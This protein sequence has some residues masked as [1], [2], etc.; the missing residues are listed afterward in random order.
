MFG[1]L[2]SEKYIPTPSTIPRIP[3]PNGERAYR[4][5]TSFGVTRSDAERRGQK[6]NYFQHR[7]ASR[8]KQALLGLRSPQY[9]FRCGFLLRR[10]TQFFFLLE[11]MD[12]TKLNHSKLGTKEYWDNFYKLEKENF[13][14]NPEDTGECWFA[15][16]GAEER[17]VDFVFS[18]LDPNVSICDLGTGNGHLL[19]EILQEGWKGQLVGVDY[20]E[21]SVQFAKTIAETHDLDVKFYQSDILNLEDQF[22]KTNAGNFDL[23]LDKGT[24]DAIA[25]SDNLYDGKTG[26]EVYPD[27]VKMLLKKN[28]VLLVTSCNFT[29]DELIK[30]IT[31]SDNFEVWK[32]IDY[33]VFEFGGVKGSAIC[34]VAFKRK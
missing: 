8:G 6:G 29:Q 7:R 1:L 17:I 18:N 9:A 20:S 22:L 5:S 32:T 13:A 3:L 21:A 12:T 28:A 14:E 11:R 27:T 23:V 2:I 4:E 33:P 26:Q 34:T 25:L 31:A 30:V 19:F 24:L 16:A 10:S 15:D